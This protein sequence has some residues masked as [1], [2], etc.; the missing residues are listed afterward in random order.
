MLNLIIVQSK[1]LI[2]WVACYNKNPL[3]PLQLFHTLIGLNS[4]EDQVEQEA[5]N[6]DGEEE[7]GQLLHLFAIKSQCL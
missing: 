4:G 5:G 1:Y 3:C 2:I 6:K 7:D